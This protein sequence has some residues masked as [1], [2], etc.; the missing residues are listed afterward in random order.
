MDRIS[1]ENFTKLIKPP[2]RPLVIDVRGGAD[3]AASAGI[4]P[5]AIRR[6]ADAVALWV[7]DIELARP[8][9]AYGSRGD[10]VSPGVSAA[11]RA[12]GHNAFYL[13]GGFQAWAANGGLIAPK[14]GAP[15]RWVTRERPKIDRIACPWLIRRFIDPDSQISLCPGERGSQS[16]KRN[17]RCSL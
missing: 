8:I 2:I 16:S 4:I 3:Y 13:Q 6:E 11:L 5:G 14:P 1:L 15:T 10:K 17:R 7:R 12:A 9:V